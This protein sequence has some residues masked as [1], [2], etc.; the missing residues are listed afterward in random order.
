M[1]G[2]Y[3]NQRWITC[4]YCK[5]HG[6]FQVTHFHL[7]FLSGLVSRSFCLRCKHQPVTVVGFERIHEIHSKLLHVCSSAESLSCSPHSSRK[8]QHPSAVNRPVAP[9]TLAC[10]YSRLPSAAANRFV[11]DRR[12]L[13]TQAARSTYRHL[14]LLELP[15]A[16]KTAVLFENEVVSSGARAWVRKFTHAYSVQVSHEFILPRKLFQVSQFSGLF[17]YMLAMPLFFQHPREATLTFVCEY[18]RLVDFWYIFGYSFR[19]KQHIRLCHDRRFRLR[20]NTG[21]GRKHL[22]CR[23]VFGWPCKLTCIVFGLYNFYSLLLVEG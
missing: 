16:D 7:V 22:V 10:R 2:H 9:T 6:R 20:K 17:L 13:Y 3:Q 1:R 23:V 11:S 5:N 4:T 21:H 15:L 18:R 19:E 8:I 12:R 14:V